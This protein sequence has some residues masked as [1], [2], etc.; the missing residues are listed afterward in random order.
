MDGA[1]QEVQLD[2]VFDESATQEELYT[3]S[4]APLVDLC[5]EGRDVAVMAWGGPVRARPMS[6]S[7]WLQ[8]ATVLL[9]LAPRR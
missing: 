2:D 3:H 5:L 1:E 6:L 4:V 7:T 8:K 9:Y